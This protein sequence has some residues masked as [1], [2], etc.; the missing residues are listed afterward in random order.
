MAGDCENYDNL[1]KFFFETQLVVFTFNVQIYE[2]HF[3]YRIKIG[4]NMISRIRCLWNN[5]HSFKVELIF[6]SN[7]LK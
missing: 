4:G 2:M 7:G 3:V 1:F 6:L 5:F